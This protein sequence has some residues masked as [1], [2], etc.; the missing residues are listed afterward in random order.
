MAW[1]GPTCFVAPCPPLVSEHC[2]QCRKMLPPPIALPQ[3]RRAAKSAPQSFD[4]A[5]RKW[6]EL[7]RV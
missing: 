7:A 5:V 4:L 2:G 6:G 1:G 3:P